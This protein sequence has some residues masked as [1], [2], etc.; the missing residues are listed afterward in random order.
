MLREHAELDARGFATNF[1]SSIPVHVMMSDIRIHNVEVLLATSPLSKIIII[2]AVRIL[3]HRDRSLLDRPHL[4][5]RL[6]NVAR[7]GQK[8]SLITKN[9]IAKMAEIFFLIRATLP[10]LPQ[11]IIS[12]R[13]RIDALLIL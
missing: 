7:P 12:Y 9:A 1:A 10:F 6:R 3:Y 2:I 11:H 4:A 8:P 5:S 13:P